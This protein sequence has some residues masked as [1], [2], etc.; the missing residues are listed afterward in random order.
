MHST[1]SV[2]WEVPK[3]YWQQ[4]YSKQ[5][6]FTWKKN[7]CPFSFTVIL[8]TYATCTER[9]LQLGSS[10]GALT[11]PQTITD[12]SIGMIY[13]T[14]WKLN[15]APTSLDSG[16]LCISHCSECIVLTFPASSSFCASS[17]RQRTLAAIQ[18]YLKK[19]WWDDQNCPHRDFLLTRPSSSA[20]RMKTCNASAHW[21]QNPDVNNHF[22][23]KFFLFEISQDHTQTQPNRQSQLIL[24]CE[25]HFTYQFGSFVI[26][27]FEVTVQS[28]LFNAERHP[29][30][31]QLPGNVHAAHFH[32]HSNNLH[33]PDTSAY[34]RHINHST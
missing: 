16:L 1:W 33:G 8:P 28:D 19:R 31:A 25:R 3:K 10:S 32:V 5:H 18:R 20:A 17:T 15:F 13:E 29:W 24:V 34:K 30:E 21:K 14:T 12:A 6:E 2:Y 22:Q 26:D 11:N 23:V 4:F 9:L 27:K 7:V